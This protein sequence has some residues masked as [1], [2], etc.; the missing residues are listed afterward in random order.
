MPINLK[1]IK[2][3][4]ALTSTY[5]KNIAINPYQGC[6]FACEFCS[7][8]KMNYFTGRVRKKW[9]A[10][11]WGE[12][13]DYKTNL[14]ELLHKEREKVRKSKIYFG[15]ATDIYMP[16]E[17][18]LK[19]V[20][21]ILEFFLENPPLELEVQTRGTS[22]DVKRDIPLLQEL[23][24]KTSVLVSYSIHT[25]RD[26]VKKIFEPKAPS[27]IERERGLKSYFE[28][29][30]ETRLS[31]MPILPLDP[32]NYAERFAKYVTKRVW[33]ASMNHKQLTNGLFKKYFPE[34]LD[35]R[36][37]EKAMKQTQAEF[38]DRGVEC[39]YAS[40]EPKAKRERWEKR[41]SKIIDRKAKS[42][43]KTETESIQPKLFN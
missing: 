17:R 21:P 43:V 40:L 8:I 27:L 4:N 18:K 13:V 12:W 30:I 31:C 14:V 7:A 28:G 41:K 6:V 1:P 22:R 3:R 5:G 15:N 37:V 2:A 9:D 26:D 33:I 38:K 23:S 24:K 11:G 10:T 32:E 34:W 39:F 16:I 29:G 42:N 25:D 35:E 20:P 19:L 36:V